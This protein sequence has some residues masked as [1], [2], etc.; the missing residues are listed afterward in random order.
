MT[1]L[2]TILSA[3]LLLGFAAC[4]DTSEQPRMT[5]DNKADSTDCFDTALDD[6]GICRTAGGQFANASCC[7]LP[8]QQGLLELLSADGAFQMPATGVEHGANEFF[9]TVE[10]IDA[11]DDNIQ[12]VMKPLLDDVANRYCE[13]SMQDFTGDHGGIYC[14]FNIPDGHFNMRH[15]YLRQDIRDALMDSISPDHRASID[16]IINEVGSNLGAHYSHYLAYDIGAEIMA[17]EIF[18]IVP[19]S[20]TDAVPAGKAII[21]HLDYSH[22]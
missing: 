8:A 19:S 21:V 1:K 2:S 17:D 4:A 18:V 7:E 15:G 6:N 16:E 3:A 9:V 12:A 14:L 13:D 20:A 10:M 5:D 22:S 11:D